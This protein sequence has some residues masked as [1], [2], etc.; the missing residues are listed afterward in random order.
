MRPRPDGYCKSGRLNAIKSGTSQQK[1]PRR[2]RETAPKRG[3]I[4]APESN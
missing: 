1:M 4:F 2:P 3:L